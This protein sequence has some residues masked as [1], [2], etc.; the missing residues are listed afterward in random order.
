MPIERVRNGNI[1][2][3]KY[4]GFG[5]LKR[6]EKGLKAFKG[7]KKRN[8]TAFNIFLTPKTEKAFK[9]NVWLDGP[10]DNATWKGKKIAEIVVPPN[11]KKEVTQYTADV[12]RFVDNLDKKHAIFLVAEGAESDTLFN[13]TGLGFSSK[14]KNLNRPVVPTVSIAVNGQAINIPATP[15]RSTNANGIVGY[16]IY[17]T[18]YKVPAGTTG[19][20]KATASS[21]NSKVNVAV[22]QAESLS[23]TAVVKFDYNG[24]VKT[25]KVVYTAE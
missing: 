22:T 4:F 24:V 1:I 3:Y 7:T 25:Y 13:M 21:N 19:V 18:T 11:S 2:G 14:K 9:V 6:D 10:W 20:P 23:G 12:S 15:V 17:Q 8:K 16:D 5:G